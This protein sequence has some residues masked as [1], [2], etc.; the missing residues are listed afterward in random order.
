MDGA[1]GPVRNPWKYRFEA[2]WRDRPGAAQTAPSAARIADRG[3][4]FH[5]ASPSQS[6]D[7]DS[8]DSAEWFIAGGSSGG[9]AVSV[10]TGAVLALVIC[11]PYES[12][13]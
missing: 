9:S 6:I 2:S 11:L 1:F 12:L 5:S 8:G 7:V 13:S 4:Q 10:A 3:R